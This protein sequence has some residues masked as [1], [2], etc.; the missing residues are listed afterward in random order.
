MAELAL[1]EVQRNALTGKLEHVCVAQLMRREPAP[2]TR[3]GSE[4]PELAAH[5][6]S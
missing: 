5:G 1:D 4:A 3:F 2:D 6:G